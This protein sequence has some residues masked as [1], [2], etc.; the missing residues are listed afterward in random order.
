MI[1][2]KNLTVKNFMSVGNQTQAVDFDKQQ[3]TL[4]LGENLDQGGDDMGSRNGTGKTT[5]VNALSYA[6]YGVALT[7]IKRNNLINKTNNKG[8]L[9]TL[10]FEK[11]GTSYKVE[12]GR[13]PNVLKFFVN[14][15]EQ[16]LVDESQG[17]SRKTQE[18]I[19]ELLGM[20]HNMFKHILAL[21]TYTEPFLSMKVND[22]KDIIE[23]LLG[24]TILSEKA[25]V[26]KEKIRQTRD[27][28]TEEN[29]KISAQQQSNERI[30]ETIDSLKLKQSAWESTKKSNLEKLQKGIDEL[31]HLD[32]DSELEKHEKLQNW[33]ELNTQI[34]NLKK[35]TS[36][37]ESALMR[38]NK[39]V[40]KVTKDIEELD[41]AVCYACGQELQEDKKKEIENTKAKELEDA[42]AYH[43]EITDKLD[44]ANKELDN[45]GDINGRPETFYETIKEV[46]DHKQ[47]VA[48]LKQALENST[49]ETDPYQEQIDDLTNTG[50]QEVDWSTINALTD[51]KEHQE[52]LLKLLTNKDSFIRKK[53]IDQNLA[54]L[55]NRL[56]HYLDKLGLPHQVVFM[57]D[58][59]VEITQLGQDLDFD[60]LSRGERNRLILGMSFAFRDVWESL[61][62]NI[63]L[64]FI[65]EL[66]DSGMDIS[67]VENSLAILK[68][69]GRERDKNVYL[70]SH[71]DELVGR[72]THVL[73][74]IKEN[75]FTSY[76]NDVEIHNE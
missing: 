3:L 18:T 72:V 45:I 56:T 65:D 42:T 44:I 69:M 50:I 75:G 19:N 10:T 15:Q 55:N 37:L 31:E 4:V 21:N 74:V 2:I 49:N 30:T 33:E 71:K 16:E 46:Y 5:I 63:N 53:I 60:N 48:Q 70:I 43:K 67:G 35:E 40:D 24:I 22:Q 12:R 59:S 47:N 28:I 34:A 76:E 38:A 9:V 54:Y 36:T 41:N 14:D 8:M 64:L 68:K 39:S 62:Q 23:Q 7:N 13:S 32:V 20:S 1:K 26:L 6:L 29:A 61:Y 58:L 11:D 27:S 25:E 17:D 73:K 66:V 51:L 52:F 57:N